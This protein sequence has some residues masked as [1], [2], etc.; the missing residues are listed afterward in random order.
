[1]EDIKRNGW[2]E[3][4]KLVISELERLNNNIEK[5][6]SEIGYI[7]KNTQKDILED[8]SIKSLKNWKY[9]MDEIQSPTQFKELVDRVDSLD[10]FKIQ[11]ITIWTVVNIVIISL[12]A[13]MK[14]LL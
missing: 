2:N 8:P 7:K 3:Y 10:K 12:F 11:A 4:S 5:L 1:M 6:E 14:F 9:S 13:I